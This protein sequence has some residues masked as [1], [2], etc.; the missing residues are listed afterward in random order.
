MAAVISVASVFITEFCCLGRQW[1]M[2]CHLRPSSEGGS[3]LTSSTTALEPNTERV[4]RFPFHLADFLC[5]AAGKPF[6]S[7]KCS[8]PLYGQQRGHLCKPC[9]SCSSSRPKWLARYPGR[10]WLLSPLAASTRHH[11][12]GVVLVDSFWSTRVPP[13]RRVHL[14]LY[15]GRGSAFVPEACHCHHLHV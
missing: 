4:P 7:Y 6:D 11:F 14:P 12:V 15:A 2:R 9:C 5:L 3:V 8:K 13:S 1:E 10:F